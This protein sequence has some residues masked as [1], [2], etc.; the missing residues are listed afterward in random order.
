MITPKPVATSIPIEFLYKKIASMKMRDLEHQIH[1]RL[2]LKEKVGFWILKQKARHEIKRAAKH[3][4][5]KSSA[6]S[7]ALI[8]G[9]IGL[10]LFVTGLFVPVL[11]IGSLVA[12]ISAIVLGST[13]IKQNS[14]D[15]QAHAG[16]LIGWITLGL[17]ALL[18]LIA[19]IIVSTWSLW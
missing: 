14:K 11:W 13:A 12:S 15:M 19:V 5:G 7:T 2:T 16:K 3:R 6:G 17:L 10:I 8:I 4:E 1:R 18:L 9:I